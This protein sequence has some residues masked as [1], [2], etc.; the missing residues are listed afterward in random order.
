MK[1]ILGITA[2]AFSIVLFSAVQNKASAQYDNP[3]TGNDVS[4]QD[5][6]D[7]LSPYGD[8][9]EYPDYGYVWQPRM[10]E[11]FR[12]Y[13][14]GGQWVWNDE[15]EWMWV[16]D[17]DWG[18]APFHYG[19]WFEDD[20]YGWLWQPGYEW[21]PAWVAWRD[22]G[23][24]YG[25]APLR[26]GINISIGFNI[27][28][29]NPPYS[30]WNFA[31]R[32]Y[33]TS[34]NIYNYCLPWRQNTVYINQTVII[35]NFNYGNSY[36][37]RT[38]PRRFEAERYC[39]PIRSV[40]FRQSYTPGRTQFRNNSVSIYRPNVRQDNGNRNFAPRQFNRYDRQSTGNRSFDRTDN[41]N[42]NR[43]VRNNNTPNRQDRTPGN[44]G[45]FDR[46]NNNNG[47][48]NQNGGGVRT[49]GQTDRPTGNTNGGGRRFDRNNNSGQSNPA[50]GGIRTPRPV[51]NPANGNGRFDR[52]NNGQSNPTGVRNRPVDNPAT[53]NGNGRFDRNN[54]Q[55]N[56]NDGAIRTPRQVERPVDANQG[57]T[58]RQF[59]RRTTN[60]GNPSREM[61][62][63]TQQQPQRERSVQQQP[64]QQ[65]QTERRP[66]VN[67]Q[68]NSGGG[69]GNSGNR[70]GGNGR[71]F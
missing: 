36:G 14:T 40:S 55:S 20:N 39:G 47:Q 8:W 63:P 59:E 61:R 69:N 48:S 68:P 26:P 46:N 66:E 65:R 30:Y 51:D 49:P 1:R 9:I 25:W 34:H 41:R 21:S 35:N 31:P 62:Q 58:N 5:F 24:N 50:D 2:L 37:F 32:R 56:P 54:R 4:Y 27:G 6:Y 33:I 10:G 67:R 52:N 28:S 38:G 64:Q 60:P 43:N 13:S 45:R 15:Y 19:R 70:G 17:Y 57:N 3:N 16:S 12:P 22:G 44:N 42:D 23:D 7:E 18:W 11:D 71:R 29:Y 53:G